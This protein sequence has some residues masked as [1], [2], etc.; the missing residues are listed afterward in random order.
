MIEADQNIN[1][2]F[3][4]ELLKD[5]PPAEPGD[6]GNDELPDIDVEFEITK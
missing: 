1:V 5:A 4:E 6:E 2:N 3:L